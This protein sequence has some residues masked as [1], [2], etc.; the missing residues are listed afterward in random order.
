MVGHD[1]P[2]ADEVVIEV[3]D[4]G[5][6]PAMSMIQ[7]GTTVR[8]ENKMSEPV[9]VMSGPLG[10]PEEPAD[11]GHSSSKAVSGLTTLQVEVTHVASSVSQIMELKEDFNSAGHYKA[12]FIPTSPG[13]YNF[14]FFGEIH[15]QQID[16]S[17]ES[18]NT[19]FDE[20]TPAN[21]VQFPVQLAAPR[22][23]ENAARGALD[24]ANEASVEASEASSSASTATLLGVVALILG[25]L[26]LV[27]GGLAFQRSGKNA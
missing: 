15:G 10:E 17:F 14:R 11:S 2:A 4:N 12:E 18:S 6:V 7:S 20:V 22:E 16:E 23:T 21:D 5:F 9:V 25:A 26:G 27:L 3:H 13:P 1:N 24:A 8:F 19:T